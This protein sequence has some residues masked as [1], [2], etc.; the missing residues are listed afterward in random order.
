[1]FASGILGIVRSC[2]NKSPTI[3]RCRTTYRNSQEHGINIFDKSHTERLKYKYKDKRVHPYSRILR[4]GAPKP[5][6]EIRQGD[7]PRLPPRRQEDPQAVGLRRRRRDRQIK[8][9]ISP[10]KT[11]L[12][13]P[14][15]ASAIDIKS[16]GHPR[17]FLPD[18]YNGRRSI[19]RLARAYTVSIHQSFTFMKLLH[20]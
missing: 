4:A 14:P 10:R 2:N 20:G 18:A 15:Y 5:D 13:S 16:N 11:R 19:T 1:M 17:Y 12:Y 3:N 9:K 6:N 7:A 8:W